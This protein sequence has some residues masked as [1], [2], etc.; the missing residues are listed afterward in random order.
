MI[1]RE[2][3]NLFKVIIY[4]RID[5]RNKSQT[6]LSSLLPRCMLFR[7]MF[8]FKVKV[9][10]YNALSI[11]NIL[12]M[13]ISLYTFNLSSPVEHENGTLF[14]VPTGGHIQGPTCAY[15]TVCCCPRI[16]CRRAI[17]PSVARPANPS[18]SVY[19]G[20]SSRQNAMR[21]S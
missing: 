21:C 16:P 3:W 18:A 1:Q 6:R 9:G 11:V 13:H 7:L 19:A 5:C 15:R 12:P 8:T 2:K 14:K 20:S 17:S 10:S 4:W